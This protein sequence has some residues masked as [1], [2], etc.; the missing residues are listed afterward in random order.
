MTEDAPSQFIQSSPKELNNKIPNVIVDCDPAGWI[1]TGLDVDDDLALIMALSL[2]SQNIIN[3]LGITITAG[4]S[5]LEFS[6]QQAKELIHRQLGFTS[7]PIL[8]G[9]SSSWPASWAS[10][11]STTNV[12]YDNFH[13]PTNASQFIIGTIMEYATRHRERIT[14]LAI[15][16]LGNIA[17]AYTQQPRIVNHIDQVVIMGGVWSQSH[18]LDYN[19]RYSPK[20]ADMVLSMSCPKLVIPIETAIEAAFGDTHLDKVIKECSLSSSLSSSSSN[21]PVICQF[22]TRLKIQRRLMPKLVNWRYSDIMPQS[23]HYNSG[24]ILWDVVALVAWI[25]SDLFDEWTYYDAKFLLPY[26]DEAEENASQRRQHQ[27]RMEPIKDRIDQTEVER[28]NDRSWW[29]YRV[30]I[31]RRLKSEAAMAAY[32]FQH[33]LYPKIDDE[34][35]SSF[36]PIL[37]ITSQLGLLPYIGVSL[38]GTFMLPMIIFQIIYKKWFAT[39]NNTPKQ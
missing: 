37:T 32:M 26:D 30:L 8:S 36:P 15:G 7:I 21:I 31:P 13:H 39:T 28:K 16:P 35:S 9:A 1:L 12:D 10:T 25:Q 24:F 17:A 20:S 34:S 19:F 23:H 6:F 14:I 33:L 3:I 18:G 29:S 11:F 2:H 4:N 38:F 27:L 22:L 5:P